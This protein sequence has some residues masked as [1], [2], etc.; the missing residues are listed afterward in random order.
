MGPMIFLLARTLGFRGEALASIAAV[1]RLEIVSRLR[2][3]DEGWRLSS[4][5]LGQRVIE[6]FA[7]KE[8]TRVTVRGLFESYPARRQFLKRPQSEGFQCRT[9]FLERAIA[10]PHLTFRWS[11]GQDGEILLPSSP[12][13]RIQR[14]YPELLHV[15]FFE[16]RIEK[17]DFALHCI[18]ADISFYRRDKKYLQIYVNR[19]KVPQWDLMSLL[20]Y[21]FSYFLPGGAHPI[22]FLFVEI[23]PSLAD[24][25]IHPAKK[26]VRIK[27][28]A[29]VRN[30]L[31]EL[32][33]HELEIRYRGKTKALKELEPLQ[34]FS[35]EELEV[36]KA[37]ESAR[38]FLNE[39]NEYGQWKH[40]SNAYASLYSNY[41]KTE[42]TKTSALSS[43]FWQKVEA[44]QLESPR[45]IGRGP[46]L[47]FSL[48]SMK[49]FLFLISM[50]PMSEFSLIH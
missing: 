29:I 46:V 33:S 41:S 18:F 49:H 47:F 45:Y 6:P 12:T 26:E 28:S 38:I 2:G 10:H 7:C 5:P 48:S 11:S 9:V 32:L 1:A 19:R 22:A 25:N 13:E 3:T 15:P 40:G 17:Q 39:N 31:H 35:F 36:P 42:Q 34:T 37:S 43:D 30:V 23:D 20:E 24:F 21:E 16:T 4:L 27:N 14:C 8:G 44:G 50:Q